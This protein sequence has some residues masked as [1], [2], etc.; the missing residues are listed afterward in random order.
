MHGESE[1]Q[2]LTLP[3]R[4][5]KLFSLTPSRGFIWQVAADWLEEQ[6]EPY[7]ANAFR[8]DI[9]LPKYE[10]NGDGSGSGSGYGYGGG[11]GDGGSGSGDGGSGSGD[12]DG[13]G[14]GYGYGNGD[15]NGN[16][17]GYGDGDGSG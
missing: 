5:M 6:G 14:N 17:N 13:N 9:Y 15:G 10:P 7:I 16:G 3:Q 11:S 1:S 8:A 2:S 12:G 4:C